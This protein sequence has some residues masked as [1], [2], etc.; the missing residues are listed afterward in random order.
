MSNKWQDFKFFDAD[1]PNPI[2]KYKQPEPNPRFSAIHGYP[3]DELDMMGTKTY[4]RWVKPLNGE[5]KERMDIRGCKNTQRGKR[6]YEDHQDRQ[7]PRTKPRSGS[8]E[9]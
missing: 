3:S 5:K 9:D 7:A 4:G 2:G 1:E 6:F 8:H